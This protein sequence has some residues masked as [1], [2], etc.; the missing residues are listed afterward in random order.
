MTYHLLPLRAVPCLTGPPVSFIDLICAL[1]LHASAPY[2]PTV[3][4]RY[5]VCEKL[6]ACRRTDDYIGLQQQI[7]IRGFQVCC[8]QPVQYLEVGVQRLRGR[9]VLL[10][11]LALGR[12]E[13][14]AARH[15]L[16][17]HL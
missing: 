9:Q 5:I 1:L 17:H 15:H 10:A 12:L 8:M 14:L 3:A 11:L 2:N 16:L 4:E 6:H 13:G 7:P